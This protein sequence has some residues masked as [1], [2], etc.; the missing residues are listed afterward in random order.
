MINIERKLQHGWDLKSFLQELSCNSEEELFELLKRDFSR[1]TAKSY[2]VRMNKNSEKHDKKRIIQIKKDTQ[3]VDSLKE[4]KVQIQAETKINAPIEVKTEKR[5]QSKG[6][7][8]K[9]INY[10]K[11]N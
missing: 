5:K 6:W 4:E 9:I 7:L 10:F 2:I 3:Q 11:K 8:S 1:K